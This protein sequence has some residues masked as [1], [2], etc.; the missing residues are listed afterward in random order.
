MP[1]S[2]YH[3]KLEYIRCRETEDYFG[4]DEVYLTYERDGV[5]FPLIGIHDMNDGDV[6]YLNFDA[7]FNDSFKIS[8]WDQDMGGADPDDLLGTYVLDGSSGSTTLPFRGHGSNYTLKFSVSYNGPPPPKLAAET[9]AESIGAGLWPNITSASLR[10][11]L[12]TRINNPLATNQKNTPLCGPAAICFG[13][14]S[15]KTSLTMANLVKD[16]YEKGKFT[17]NGKTFQPRPTLLLSTVPNPSSGRMNYAD[18]MMMATIRDV[19]NAYMPVYNGMEDFT[20]ITLPWEM[21]EWAQ[22][23]F[24]R[25]APFQLSLLNSGFNMMLEAGRAYLESGV[26]YLLVNANLIDEHQKAEIYPNHLV[27]FLTPVKID[28]GNWYE[29]NG[30]H[31][32]FSCQS[33][34][35]KIERS[36]GE[37]EFNKGFWGVM[38][39]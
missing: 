25:Q 32:T 38:C 17:Y 18:W 13:L 2:K 8:V 16:L 37:D 4:N 35:K 23:F 7:D 6:W 21:T 31:I 26:A 12:K 10:D 29:W 39:G 19:Y 3:I 14:A 22:I 24:N 1:Y 5:P 20:G 9:I 27:S 11:D 33:W 15:D 34:G 36:M 28:W 30:G